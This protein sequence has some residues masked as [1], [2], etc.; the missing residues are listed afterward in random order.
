MISEVENKYMLSLYLW[1]YLVQLMFG[2][3]IEYFEDCPRFYFI[4]ITTDEFPFFCKPSR[5]QFSTIQHESN[6]SILFTRPGCD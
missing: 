4:V 3:F 5:S 2:L 1:V 6:L